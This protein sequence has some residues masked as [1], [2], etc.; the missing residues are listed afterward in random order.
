MYEIKMPKMGLTM[1]YGT[2]IRWHKK[3]GD[4]VEKGEVILEIM[5]DKVNLEVESYE[6]GYL[7]KIIKKEDEEVPIGE[8]I[9]LINEHQ[10]H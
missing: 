1:E 5:T 7:A 4:R 9:G 8:T 6:E 10:D 2:I 3:E